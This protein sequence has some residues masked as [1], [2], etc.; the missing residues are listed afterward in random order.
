MNRDESISL[1][2]KGK[3]DWNEWAMAMLTKK[4]KLDELGFPSLD[5]EKLTLTG[6][7][8]EYER[9][10][11]DAYVDFT[12]V[13]FAGLNSLAHGRKKVIIN[14]NEAIDRKFVM[15]RTKQIDF[16]G[17]IFPDQ[18]SF[19][20]SIFRGVTH[21]TGARFYDEANFERCVFSNL[22]VFAKSIFFNTARFNDA[23]FRHQA[24]FVDVKLKNQSRFD[25][26]RF[27]RMA[28]FY[29]TAFERFCSFE[30][31]RFN[32]HAN[33]EGTQAAGGFTLDKAKFYHQVPSFIQANFIEAPRLDM[34]SVL[35]PPKYFHLGR[36]WHLSKRIC[37]RDYLNSSEPHRIKWRLP[38]YNLVEWLRLR[39][40]YSWRNFINHHRDADEE[41]RYRALK[42]LAI[43]AHDHENELEF[44]AGE[45]RAR[46]HLTD[47][48]N[49]FKHGPKSFLRYLAGIAYDLTS[50]V[51][52]SIWRPFILFAV[53]FYAFTQLY[54][55]QATALS[56]GNCANSDKM[57]ASYA[58][59]TIAAKNSLL[60]LGTD[61]TDKIK[62]AYTCLYG[63]AP[64]YENP[65][66]AGNNR[67]KPGYE[68]MSPT[69][70]H[71]APNVPWSVS[72]IGT[73][74]SIVS[75]ILIFLLL[76]AIR[77]QFK[78]K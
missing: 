31:A 45:L 5:R 12:D 17:F 54:I 57:T 34:V 4:A 3:D 44:F 10:L 25:N 28:W 61:R 69:S 52:R 26:V 75:L 73:A 53:V 62:R 66:T 77:N 78:I 20:N 59:Y 36:L 71:M 56:N 19:K 8:S 7:S 68:N 60:F 58:A 30:K 13:E 15:L 9:W 39:L 2:L 67:I 29:Q 22:S 41:A 55:H 33:F 47:S 35:P 6:A 14:K 46:R 38:R 37:Q 63:A 23:I 32:G 40:R 16:S 72:V 43:Q 42:R 18:C 51:G 11:K 64:I 1:L 49:I 27:E 70:R 74:H 50:D 65:S 76:L 21:F 24:M 48:P